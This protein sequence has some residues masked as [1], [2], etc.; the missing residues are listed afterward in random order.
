MFQSI[1][2]KYLSAWGFGCGLQDFPASCAIFCCSV[3]TPH[4]WV[5]CSVAGIILVPWP[6]IEPMSPALQ[7]R[8][9]TTKP[10]GKSPKYFLIHCLLLLTAT[11]GVDRKSGVWYLVLPGGT[12]VKNAPACAEDAGLIP[13]SG[14]PPGVGNCKLVQYSFLKNSMD[15]GAW[16]AT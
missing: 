4:L 5:S 7:G 6:R 8:F 15:R 10:P 16:Q 3:W 12:V 9:L 14:R 1:F 2:E 11:C 13:G